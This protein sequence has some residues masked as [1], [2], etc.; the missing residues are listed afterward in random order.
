MEN[1]IRQFYKICLSFND[2]KLLFK[3]K[4]DSY[5][6]YDK[7]TTFVRKSLQNSEECLSVL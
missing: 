2:I 5:G 1:P 4:V 7:P 6:N 3:K